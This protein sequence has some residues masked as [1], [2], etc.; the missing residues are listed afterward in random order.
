MINALSLATRHVVNSAWAAIQAAQR[1]V[2]AAAASG[3]GGGG[4]G[5]G[6]SS[7][8]ASKAWRSDSDSDNGDEGEEGGSGGGG[9]GAD[10]VWTWD[11]SEGQHRR[12]MLH[13]RKKVGHHVK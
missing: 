8:S 13:A 12:F 5:G 4:S 11:A 1:D 9:G 10:G 2:P 7:S 6:V 3:G